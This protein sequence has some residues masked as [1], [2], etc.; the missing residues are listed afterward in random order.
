MSKASVALKNNKVEIT[1]NDIAQ[2]FILP[3]TSEEKAQ[4]INELQ[5]RFGLSVKDAKEII[6]EIARKQYIQQNIFT[7]TIKELTEELKMPPEEAAAEKARAFSEK[8]IARQVSDIYKYEGLQFFA[9]ELQITGIASAEARFSKLTFLCANK[10]CKNE[11]CPLKK[12]VVFD[13]KKLEQLEFFS[14]YFFTNNYSKPPLDQFA[15]CDGWKRS[16]SMRGEEEITIVKA[17]VADLKGTEVVAQFINGPKCDLSKLPSWIDA[18]GFISTAE[19]NKIII[20]IFAF[21]ERAHVLPPTEEEV[22]KA[23]GILRKYS[24]NNNDYIY[25]LADLL[26]KKFQLKG[27]EATNGLLADL[28]LDALPVWIKTPEGPANLPGIIIEVGHTTAAKSQRD[29]SF[30]EW[31]GA[32]DYKKGR[33]TEAGLTA[34]LEKVERLGYVARK[35]ILPTSD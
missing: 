27:Q 10:D 15:K 21:S 18:E 32:G 7:K 24:E 1:Y 8:P 6:E 3:A 19:R 35:G 22:E 23:R 31:V 28:I 5:N 26:R 30:V 29:L 34:G 9:G 2:T 4:F 16:L 17:L 13:F 14:Y 33:Q 11:E 20:N 25:N 12:G